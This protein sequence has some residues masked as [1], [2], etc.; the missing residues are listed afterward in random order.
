MAERAYRT[1]K[2]SLDVRPIRHHLEQRVRCHFFMFLLA[3]YVCFEV[4]ARLA[5][6]LYT[7]DTPLTPADPVA[8]ATRSPAAKAKAATSSSAS[9]Q[10]QTSP[11]TPKPRHRGRSRNPGS[12]TS[13]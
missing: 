9:S 11:E 13:V 8:P 1:I 5:P 2:T 7:G 12:K 6:M 3:Y 10:S 4:Q